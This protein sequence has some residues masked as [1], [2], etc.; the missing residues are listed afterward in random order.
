MVLLLHTVNNA[1][2]L[3]TLDY[4]SFFWLFKDSE[5]MKGGH[6][7]KQVDPTRRW[8][9]LIFCAHVARKYLNADWDQLLL[10]VLWSAFFNMSELLRYVNRGTNLLNAERTMVEHWACNILWSCINT[11]V[12][13]WYL[14]WLPGLLRWTGALKHRVDILEP[15][16][17]GTTNLLK[18]ALSAPTVERVYFRRM[19][20]WGH[21][22]WQQLQSS[23]LGAGY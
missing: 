12:G 14:Q 15:A 16:I 4:E 22:Q 8:T 3:Q 1:I 9:F 19:G 21:I 18:T 2:T 23:N 13:P 17:N 20:C 11:W 5:N 6:E 7:F 10:P